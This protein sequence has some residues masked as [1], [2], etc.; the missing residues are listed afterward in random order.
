MEHSF[1]CMIYY[2]KYLKSKIVFLIHKMNKNWVE[3]Q[4]RNL[5]EYVLEWTCTLHSNPFD[6]PLE[7]TFGINELPSSRFN[8]VHKYLQEECDLIWQSREQCRL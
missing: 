3:M 8:V 1:S 7:F 6:W 5:N 2:I 4:V